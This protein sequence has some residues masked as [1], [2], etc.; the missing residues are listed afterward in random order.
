MLKTYFSKRNFLLSLKAYFY[1]L[2]IMD[3]GTLL[4]EMNDSKL[5]QCLMD[6]LV[7]ILLVLYYLWQ[8][9]NYTVSNTV[10]EQILR[11]LRK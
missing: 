6:Y 7:C 1:F 5:V 10:C 9:G 3:Y 8:S 2:N 4:G 11:M